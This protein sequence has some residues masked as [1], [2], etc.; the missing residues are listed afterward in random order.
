MAV[1]PARRAADWA[2]LNRRT[3]IPSY[4]RL[5]LFIAPQIEE[6]WEV[7]G[8]IEVYGS[9]IVEKKARSWR[10]R[11]ELQADEPAAE[12]QT[13]LPIIRKEVRL[14]ILF[15]RANFVAAM[16]WMCPSSS[17]IESIIVSSLRTSITTLMASKII[18]IKRK[19]F[20]QI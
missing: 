15:M 3:V 18:G 12:A 17:T 6:E 13:L 9:Y 5:Q 19:A 20:A 10:P 4:H 11:Q 2:G 16:L 7:A 1:V 14:I 8:T